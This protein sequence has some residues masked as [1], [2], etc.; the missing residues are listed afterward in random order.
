MT[1]SK[2]CFVIMPF[3]EKEDAEGKTIDF[4]NVYERLIKASIEGKDNVC[5]GFDVRCTRCDEIAEGGWIH[6]KMIQR[7]HSSDL[8]IVDISTL[9]P[10]V[11]YEIGIAHT[12]VRD[13]LLIT[14]ERNDVPFDLR[15]LRFVE[16]AN[17]AQGHATLVNALRGR[18][19]A[20]G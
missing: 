8:A 11:F 17:N 14:Q 19:E 13:V 12:L 3:G 16:Y 5:P 6:R 9:N 4:D 18:L 2:D 10:N 15:H 20:L 7:I 1:I